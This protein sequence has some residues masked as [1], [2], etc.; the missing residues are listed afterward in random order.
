MDNKTDEMI[1]H[2][3]TVIEHYL[4]DISFDEGEKQFEGYPWLVYSNLHYIPYGVQ[5]RGA[6]L[7]DAVKRYEWALEDHLGRNDGAHK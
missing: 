1:L 4:L 7:L 5:A 3:W 6:T 2:A